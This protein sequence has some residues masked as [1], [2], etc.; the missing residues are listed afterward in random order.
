MG[1]FP[2]QTL[3]R[4]NQTKQTAR[5]TLDWS[6]R[7]RLPEEL[8]ADALPAEVEIVFDEGSGCSNPPPGSL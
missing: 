8:V 7:L 6:V 3:T 5:L 1:Y 2:I 4:Y